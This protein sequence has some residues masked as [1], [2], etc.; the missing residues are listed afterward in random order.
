MSVTFH[1]RLPWEQR[2]GGFWQAEAG[3]FTLRLH[4]PTRTLLIA[5]TDRPTVGEAGDE[6]GDLLALAEDWARE[7]L[8]DGE[9]TITTAPPGR[10]MMC[11]PE[12]DR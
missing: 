7:A 4:E 12:Y 1:R 5:L 8:I 3:P 2:P 11:I 10:T 9:A 6:I